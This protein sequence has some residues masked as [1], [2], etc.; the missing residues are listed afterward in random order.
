M[1]YTFS[2]A[3]P[4]P[5][6]ERS[7]AAIVDFFSRQPAVSTVLLTCSC[8]RGRASRDPCLDIAVLLL[9][10]LRP[11]PARCPASGLATALPVRAG[12]RGAAP[13]RPLQ[14]G[15]SG[16]PHRRVRPGPPSPRVDQR[17]GWFRAGGGQPAG[18]Q[19]P[20][21]G[22]R[23]HLSRPARPLA[24]LLWRRPAPGAAGDGPGILPQ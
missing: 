17:R 10:G 2:P 20:T 9:P 6:H 18:L 11:G 13:G 12:I 4:T 22:T 1:T 16:F 24:A 21:V 19:L 7:A 5:Q 3:Y 8:A 15:R 14:P 23:P